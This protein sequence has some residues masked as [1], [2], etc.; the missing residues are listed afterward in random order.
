[1]S[2]GFMAGLTVAQISEFSLIL[3]ALGVKV[4]HISNEI[5][6]FVTIVGLIT[7]AGSTYLMIY[8][9]KIYPYFSK[10]FK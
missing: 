4:G 1:K 7:I 3:I 9:D 6:S 2:T 5:L 8:S 10:S